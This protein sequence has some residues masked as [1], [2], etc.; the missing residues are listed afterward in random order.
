[1]VSALLQDLW[2]RRQET[3]QRVAEISHGVELRICSRKD[4]GM[5]NRRQRGLRIGAFKYDSLACDHIEIGRYP[6][7]ATQKAHVVSAGGIDRDENN[8]GGFSLNNS[9]QCGN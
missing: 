7:G 5:R 4:G 3:R 8:V 2:D 9:A 1:M 6:T